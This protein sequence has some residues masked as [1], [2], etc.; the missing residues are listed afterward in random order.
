M[1]FRRPEVLKWFPI[2][3][4]TF[5][6]QLDDLVDHFEAAVP[7]KVHWRKLW[8]LSDLYR[9]VGIEYTVHNLS[10]CYI[11]GLEMY[12]S[13]KMIFSF[14]IKFNGGPRNPEPFEG[15]A[16]GKEWRLLVRYGYQESSRGHYPF[17]M[18]S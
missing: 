9:N 3:L 8:I 14:I 4:F 12:L 7:G 1:T 2:S 16:G 17:G 10:G 15:K 18:A 11:E 5:N 13:K 6:T